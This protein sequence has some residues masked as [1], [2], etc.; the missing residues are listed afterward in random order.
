MSATY[1]WN[2]AAFQAVMKSPEVAANLRRRAEAIA[3][4][5]GA[6]HEVQSFTGRT[7]ARVTVRTV[8]REARLAEAQDRNLSAA[9][10]AGRE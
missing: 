1:T 6:G 10:D 2:G 5:A 4:R 3:A 7:R 9:L 8:T